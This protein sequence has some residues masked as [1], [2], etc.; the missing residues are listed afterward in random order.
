MRGVPRRS[1]WR[2]S[3]PTSTTPARG[4]YSRSPSA[5]LRAAG[6]R[7]AGVSRR[8]ARA[9]LR[10]R[11]PGGVEDAQEEGAGSRPA[12]FPSAPVG[13]CSASSTRRRAVYS[14]NAWTLIRS[15]PRPGATSA[16][17]ITARTIARRASGESLGSSTSTVSSVGAPALAARPVLAPGRAPRAVRAVA[18]APTPHPRIR[19]AGAPSGASCSCAACSS[20]RASAT[21]SSTVARP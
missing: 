9:A 4:R 1:S 3:S 7:R 6:A 2:A 8:R 20:R 17:S 16:R 18:R 14:P 21:R 11:L 5:T 10:G 15:A 12:S 19:S 13:R